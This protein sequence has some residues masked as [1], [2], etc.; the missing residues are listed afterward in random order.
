MN[1][2]TLK[3]VAIR[4]ANRSVLVVKKY[5]PEILLGLGI[6]GMVSATVIACKATTKA[7]K[8]IDDAKAKLDIVHEASE[9]FSEEKYSATDRQVD[10]LTVYAQTGFEFVKLY[11]PAVT[12]GALSIGCIV[13]SYGIMKKRNLALVA[14]YKVMEEGFTKYR[15]RVVDEYG[16]EKDKEFRYGIK[17]KTVTETITD[18]TTGETKKVKKTMAYIPARDAGVYARFFDDLNPQWDKDSPELNFRFLFA[19]QEHF[20]FLLHRNGHVFL[21][22]VYKAVGIDPCP[23]GQLV[24]WL[25]NPEKTKYIDFGLYEYH[26]EYTRDFVNRK[27]ICFLMDFNV[28][29][30]PIY[31]Q[32]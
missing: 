14:A 13:A 27:A 19:Q 17:Q 6:V 20:N 11:G 28:D 16:E 3:A 31:D 4:K 18:P 24:G 21:N 10:T 5:S 12:L 8:I 2:T 23:D 32:I 1:L 26:D 15:K 9:E 29:P 25:D 22:D 30:E 7:E